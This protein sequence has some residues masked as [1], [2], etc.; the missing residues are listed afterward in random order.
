MI[1]DPV[2]LAALQ[3]ALIAMVSGR[4][5]PLDDPRLQPAEAEWLRQL[6][7]S[8]GLEV[9]RDVHRWWRL[10]RLRASLPLTCLLIE[11]AD[12][13]E[14]IYAQYLE[15]CACRG[16]FFAQEGEQFVRALGDRSNPGLHPYVLPLAR[17]ELAI[18]EAK[19]QREHPSSRGPSSY[20]TSIGMPV[21]P[22]LLIDALLRSDVLPEPATA[23]VRVEIDSKI[24]HGWRVWVPEQT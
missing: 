9:T 15:H 21:D 17:F 19:R 20:S 6:E 16:F 24:E 2:S 4:S 12:D 3:T 1:G 8:R 23:G 11:R 22:R 7:S 10:A 13:H 18:R 14:R 5:A